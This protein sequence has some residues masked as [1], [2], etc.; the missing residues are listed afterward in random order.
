MLA[1]IVSIMFGLT[2]GKECICVYG[3]RVLEEPHAVRNV[4][5]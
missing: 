3:I 4:I 2:L 1:L 5:D